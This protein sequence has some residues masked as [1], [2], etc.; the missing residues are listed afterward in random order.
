MRLLFLALLI[1]ACVPSK[2][3]K[4][5]ASPEPVPIDAPELAPPDEEIEAPPEGEPVVEPVDEPEEPIEEPEATP[6]PTPEPTA[7]ATPVPTATPQPT[8]IAERCRDSEYPVVGTWQNINKLEDVYEFNDDCTFTHETC[9]LYA[10]QWAVWANTT[11]NTAGDLVMDPTGYNA[12]YTYCQ[13]HPSENYRNFCGWNRVSDTRI[14]LNC[15]YL[16]GTQTYER[17]SP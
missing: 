4:V 8:P 7:A 14:L 12:V 10:R 2:D 6:D 9:G 16:L 15:H 17:V 11:S 1:T 5:E 13:Q 3:T